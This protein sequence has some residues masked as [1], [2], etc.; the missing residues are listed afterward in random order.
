MSNT[1][2]N[3]AGSQRLSLQALQKWEAL[4]FGMFISFGMSTF[5]GDEFSRGD[6]PSTVYAPD[7]LDVSQWI[8]V[9][10]DAGMK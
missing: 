4:R 6:Q 9:A 10:R 1:E 5:D 2:K 7:N 8:G 3:P